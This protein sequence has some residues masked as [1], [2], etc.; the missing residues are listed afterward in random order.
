M[1]CRNLKMKNRKIKIH[2]Y[3]HVLSDHMSARSYNSL[4]KVKATAINQLSRLVHKVQV[5]R[6]VVFL[7]NI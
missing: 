4:E 2:V 3:I 5:L 1:A 6:R 7:H